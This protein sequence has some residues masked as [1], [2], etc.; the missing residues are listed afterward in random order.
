MH[1]QDMRD[2][3]KRKHKDICRHGLFLLYRGWCP[4]HDLR[5]MEESKR[6]L[7][8]NIRFMLLYQ[9]CSHKNTL[10]RSYFCHTCQTC[11]KH[12]IYVIWVLNVHCQLTFKKKKTLYLYN[13]SHMLSLQNQMLCKIQQTIL[14]IF[15]RLL[16]W[17]LN[18]S[19]FL[20]IFYQIWD[21]F[22]MRINKL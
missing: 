16:F 5:T 8:T 14:G 17:M 11:Q 12:V 19:I 18:S 2:W 15:T 7:D 4:T 9:K 22:W 10:L 13:C 20:T 1:T 3:T 6:T 21:H